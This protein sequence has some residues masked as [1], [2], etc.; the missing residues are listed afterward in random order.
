MIKILTFRSVFA[1][2]DSIVNIRDSKSSVNG[3][4]GQRLQDLDSPEI[5]FLP[6]VFDATIPHLRA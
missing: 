4:D 3:R 1:K 2:V 5:A 6:W